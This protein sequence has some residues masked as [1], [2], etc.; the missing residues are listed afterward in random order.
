[1]NAD[2]ILTQDNW[3]VHTSFGSEYLTLAVGRS[4]VGSGPRL[5]Q[6]AL[7][8][9]YLPSLETAAGKLFSFVNIL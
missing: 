8:K 3:P 9:K 4:S 6:C 5:K 2:G 7:W 1:M